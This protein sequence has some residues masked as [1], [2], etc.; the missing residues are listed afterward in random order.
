M[1]DSEFDSIRGTMPF[2]RLT[3]EITREMG[4]TAGHADVLKLFEWGLDQIG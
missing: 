4:T 3:E 1:R 2:Q